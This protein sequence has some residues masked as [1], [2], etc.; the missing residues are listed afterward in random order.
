MLI[1]ILYI[2]S[3]FVTGTLLALALY[4]LRENIAR[5]RGLVTEITTVGLLIP[6]LGL[7]LLISSSNR[8]LQE[9]WLPCLE[10]STLFVSLAFPLLLAEHLLRRLR[11]G[12]VH[13]ADLFR[14][15]TGVAIALFV[16]NAFGERATVYSG[17]VFILTFLM[18][19]KATGSKRPGRNTALAFTSGFLLSIGVNMVCQWYGAPASGP[20]SFL[21]LVP[22]LRLRD[23]FGFLA[24][25]AVV[26]AAVIAPF[27]ARATR[28]HSR[29]LH[30]AF[31]RW[32]AWQFGLGPVQND[33]HSACAAGL[34]HFRRGTCFLNHG[35]FGAAPLW[36][37]DRQAAL[38]AEADNQPMDFL[39]RQLE[40]KWLDARF[41]LATWLGTKAE[42][43]A[44][45]ENATTGMN[46]I[47]SWFP[48]EPGDEVLLNDHEYGA[49]QRIWQRACER[50]GARLVVTTLPQPFQ[51]HE[52]IT[53]SIL[54]AC[55][56]RTK[57]VVISHITSPTAV[58]L[59]VDDLCVQLK[60]RGIATCVDGPHALLQEQLHLGQL[61]CDFYTAS[62]HK[63]LCAPRGSGFV[64]IDPKWHAQVKPALLSWGRLPP[65]AR[66]QW[67]DE[68]LWTGTRDYSPYLI[69][70]SAIRFFQ[71]FDKQRLDARNHL[72]A[73]Y[74]REQLLQLD[75]TEPV[76]PLGRDWFGWMVAV[77]LPEGEHM[78]LQQR[79]FEQHQIEVP[80]VHFGNRFLVRV[81]CHLYNH[82]GQIDFLVRALQEEISK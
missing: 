20:M 25:V 79:L 66:E 81:S 4:I 11:H 19:E 18:G 10:C 49:V 73:C 46:E 38:Q 16:Y 62:C 23:P 65:T 53:D 33:I 3:R 61:D 12:K 17:L 80:I 76:T 54:A 77:W 35:S 72:L 5:R 42:N 57:L 64:Y 63:W 50:S 60:K 26:A 15:T 59:P 34:W 24:I 41:Q 31:Y 44:F 82:T 22:E 58:I 74:A 1:G 30:R 67:W 13:L 9:P 32:L 14:L 39:V 75:G 36:I 69:V 43:I 37:R 28:L 2:A 70:P 40:R 6:L 47:A 68:L 51:S 7:V 45:C 52:G 55:T 56:P 71:A 21:Y 8:T 48:L 78:T 29:V 27:L